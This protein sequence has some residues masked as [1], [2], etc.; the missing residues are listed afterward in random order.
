MLPR[1]LHGEGV[2]FSLNPQTLRD[3]GAQ[4][5][6][7]GVHDGSKGSPPST[8][9]PGSS[10]NPTLAAV[11]PQLAEQISSR[12]PSRPRPLPSGP[13][14]SIPHPRL[15]STFESARLS[16]T[17][18]APSGKKVKVTSWLKAVRAPSPKAA[19]TAPANSVTAAAF[20][21]RA[22]GPQRPPPAGVGD[23]GVRTRSC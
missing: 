20:R 4:H 12:S 11:D 23:T 9:F 2:S 8:V 5:Q 16:L 22:R 18:V 10:L 14:C 3:Q 1:L 6:G 19:G 21:A 17:T 13:R 7:L 15:L